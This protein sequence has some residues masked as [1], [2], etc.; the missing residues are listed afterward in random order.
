MICRIC[1]KANV[2]NNIVQ[3]V[4]NHTNESEITFTLEG[5]SVFQTTNVVFH[6]LVQ[7]FNGMTIEKRREKEA[8]FLCIVETLLQ[9]GAKPMGQ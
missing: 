5:Q 9:V 6:I 2:S 4:I 8:K 3:F 7:T 1:A